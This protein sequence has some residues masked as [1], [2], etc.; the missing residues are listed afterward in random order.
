MSALN[1][2]SYIFEIDHDLSHDPGFMDECSTQVPGT[3]DQVGYRYF[4]IGDQG[5]PAPEDSVAWLQQS[6]ESDGPI[7]VMSVRSDQLFRDLTPK[8]VA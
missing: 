3:E 1:P 8:Q 2:G 5:G 7:E 4:G 6:I